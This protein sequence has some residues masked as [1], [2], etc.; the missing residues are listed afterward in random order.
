MLTTT[1]DKLNLSSNVSI[2]ATARHGFVA[3]P[4]WLMLSID[5]SNQ[6]MYIAAV[7]SGDKAMLNSFLPNAQLS[8]YIPYL[9]D[10]GDVFYK[11]GKP[12]MVTNP[13]KDMHTLTAAKCCYPKLFEGQPT[14]KWVEIAKNK[15]LVKGS[16]T[17]RDT[18]KSTNFGLLYLQT[19]K[20]MSEQQYVPVKV[21]EEWISNHKLTYP[22]FWA[23][24]DEIAQL[25]T[26][27][28]WARNTSTGRIRWV[29]EDNSKAQGAS[30]AR[31]GVNH[32][33]QGFAADMSKKALVKILKYSEQNP[34]L[35]YMGGLIH[36]EVL[37]MARGR[38]ILDN[39]K[40]MF[41][42]GIFKPAYKLEGNIIEVAETCK[43]L[44]EEAEH[45]LFGGQWLGRS[46]YELSPFW[47]H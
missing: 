32:M 33:I 44:M 30:P 24:S 47:N 41:E 22:Q 43:A 28:G 20:A 10:E 26:V 5:Y 42:D 6:E 16:K 11:D 27:R 17:P 14:H 12:V 3:P 45:S 8:D 19:A 23:W 13:D 46:E 39:S 34:G 2:S 15:K 37:I 7:Q 4:G 29:A 38:L 25:C 36:D 31:S 18:G 21:A 9:T 40:Y 35:F 1:L